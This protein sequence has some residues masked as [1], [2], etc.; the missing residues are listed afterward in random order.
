M[1]V[2][3]HTH[4]HYSLLDGLPKIGELV[5]H[6]KN[7]GF[8]ALGLTDHGAMYGA[9][10]FYKKCTSE[11]IKPI[12]GFEAY[13]APRGREVK[14]GRL[15]DHP[16]HITLLAKNFD[17]YRNLMR[18]SSIGHLEGFYYKPRIDWETLQKHKD[19][20]IVLSGCASSELSKL[21][22][23]EKFKEA[24]V[25]A[26]Q[27]KK[28]FTDDYYIEIQRQPI[29]GDDE[30]KSRREKLNQALVKLS[31]QTKIP[32]VATADSHYLEPSDA[33]AQDLL[34]CIETGKTVEDVNRLD[35]RSVDLSLKTE[36]EMEELF[37]DLLD[38]VHESGKIADKVSIEIPLRVWAFPHYEIPK[39]TSYEDYLTKQSREGIAKFYEIKE[40]DL[41]KKIPQV[42]ERLDY[43]LNI[44]CKKGYAPYFLIVSDFA[45]W[46]RQTGIVTTTRGSAAGSLVAY[47]L[48]ITTINPLTYN[49]PFERFLNLERPLPPDIDMD[50]ADNRRDEVISYVTQKYGRDKVAQIV[51]FGT[52]M[53]RAA[54]RDVGRA[55]G[56][57]YNKCDRIA[58]MIPFGKQG[59]H[60]TITE[61]LK[62]SP[63]L[64]M[65][66]DKDEE[67][68]RII[69]LAKKVEGAARHASI[70]AAG[71]VI[72][73]EPLTNYT[74]LRMDSETGTV[75]TQYD[76]YSVEE[77]GLVKMDFLGIRNLSILGTAVELVEKIH[78]TKVK[79]DQLPLDDKKT[80]EILAEGQTTGLFQL[81]GSGMTKYLKDLQPTKVEDIMAMIALY[82]PGPMESIPE[83]I[84]RKHDPRLI[85]YLDPRLEEILQASYGI[86]TYQDDVLLIAIKLAGYTWQEADKLRKA[87]GKK[88][89]REMAE[90]KEKFIEGCMNKGLS[91]EKAYR[92]WGLI[93]PFAAYGFNKSH[94]AS[95]GIV[96]YQTAFMKANYP[97]EF[98]ASVLTAEA[99]NMETIAEAVS[100]CGHMGIKVLPPDVNESLNNFTV[101]NDHTIRFGL[102]A[103][104]NLGSDVVQKIIEEREANGKFKSLTD[105]ITRTFVRNFNKKS[106]EALVRSGSMEEFGERN[107]LLQN[108]DRVLNFARAH[109]KDQ[110]SPQ[111]SLFGAPTA[112]EMKIQL[113]E[114]PPATQ[115]EKLMWEKEL[116]GL[117]LSSHPLK[118]YE[119]VLVKLGADIKAVKADLT[120]RSVKIAG[121]ITKVKNILTKKGDQMC[122]AEIEDRTG[123][124]ELVVF[125]RVFAE[126][127]PLL[128]PDKIV[129]IS[130]RVSPKDN[131][132]KILVN[133]IDE[134]KPDGKIEIKPKKKNVEPGDKRVVL[135]IPKDADPAIFNK[136]KIVFEKFPGPVRVDLQLSSGDS[137]KQLATDFMVNPNSRFKEQVKKI[138]HA[139]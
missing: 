27:Y 103:V 17:G 56:I 19:G 70:H 90:Q 15:E 77:T 91:S 87:M 136:L 24:I 66:Y 21:L 72:S 110:N 14:Q 58:K 137:Q 117:Y 62:I 83:F 123:T 129:R 97:V 108:S 28:L 81:G 61:A 105:F 112:S 6:A 2:H 36:K 4:S 67:T 80:F 79:L 139:D 134:L 120:E 29:D 1:F 68:K 51:T 85:S 125:P 26:E 126:S 31:R 33:D 122:F 35:M 63:E 74:P 99:G 65:A 111:D 124:V 45:Q 89:P 101:I 40:N 107:Q 135:P 113:D 12:I 116:L 92:L 84:R 55:L 43:E 86:L 75:T 46:S 104:K 102:S 54:V 23:A 115:L 98:M 57:A 52:M 127:R 20:L 130:G 59:F 82:R 47:S 114:V 138:L 42:M 44:I 100:E 128:E 10:E 41:E 78:K 118:E 50:F 93:E 8:T 131:E 11:G 37:P 22:I 16:Y 133:K 38:C 109:I 64:K 53:A 30:F 49:L 25:L 69:D 32:L 132:V 88:I 13:V 60:M 48:G 3:L 121:I 76:M 34:V 94:A 7:K 119:Q 106:W 9:I 95:Y 71:V 39:N 96:A 18:L 73:P 5:S